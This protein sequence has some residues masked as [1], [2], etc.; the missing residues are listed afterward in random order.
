MEGYLEGAG[1]PFSLLRDQAYQTPSCKSAQL[2]FFHLPRTRLCPTRARHI[3]RKP[4]PSYYLGSSCPLLAVRMLVQ[5]QA[6]FT[7]LVH[8]QGPPHVDRACP[9]GQLV[10]LQGATDLIVS[11]ASP[12]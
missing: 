1:C 11:A 2:Q 3:W 9:T 7:T 6:S 12:E 4:Y 10:N 5:N 8:N